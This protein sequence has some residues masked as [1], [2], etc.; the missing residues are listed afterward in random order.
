M[1]A[2]EFVTN[3]NK[4]LDEIKSVINPNLLIVIDKLTS[5]DPHELVGPETMFLNENDARGI[6]WCRFVECVNEY[7]N[8]PITIDIEDIKSLDDIEMFFI[9]LEK[10]RILYH[11]ERSFH[12]NINTDINGKC[13][14]STFTFEESERLDLLMGKCRGLCDELDIDLYEIGKRANLIVRGKNSYN[15][16]PPT[17]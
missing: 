16:S 1:D 17:E 10:E 3:Y 14:V 5:I 15:Q 11:P 4:Y 2:S 7:A 9:L 13:T 6:V 8:Q 12:G